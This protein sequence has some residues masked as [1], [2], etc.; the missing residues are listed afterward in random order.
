MHEKGPVVEEAQKKAAKWLEFLL[1]DVRHNLSIEQAL[2]SALSD[3]RYPEF[4]FNRAELS[5]LVLSSLANGE[6]FE[7]NALC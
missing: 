7:R 4:A 2:Y 6:C 3:R 5:R 1:A